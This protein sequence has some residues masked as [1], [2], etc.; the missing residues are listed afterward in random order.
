MTGPDPASIRL[1]QA[2][3][4]FDQR[5]LAGTIGPQQPHHLTG[6]YRQRHSV[7]RPN[8]TI[9]LDQLP[10]GQGR[11]VVQDTTSTTWLKPPE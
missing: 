4:T 9:V 8:R 6:G 2:Q 11:V 10:D 5:G 3:Q 1:A 7:Q